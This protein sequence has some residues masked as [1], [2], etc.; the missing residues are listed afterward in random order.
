M[1]HPY[2]YNGQERKKGKEKS[3]NLPISPSVF[4][5][6]ETVDVDV[7][8]HPHSD[9]IHREKMLL[10]GNT[11]ILSSS[12]PL[13]TVTR[14]TQVL[15]CVHSFSLFYFAPFLSTHYHY[16][17]SSHLQHPHNIISSSH[18]IY[19]PIPTK[20]SRQPKERAATANPLSW[21]GHLTDPMTMK[22]EYCCCCCCDCD[23]LEKVFLTHSHTKT[24][25]DFFTTRTNQPLEREMA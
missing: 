18:I 5:P 21:R 1:Y 9:A 2:K 20:L 16:L 8:S 11:I 14:H 22:L 23:T 17:H 25:D 6:L 12:S 7:D 19:T 10:V 13:V 3:R 24:K 15:C 4:L